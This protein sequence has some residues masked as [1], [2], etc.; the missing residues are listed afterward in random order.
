[1]QARNLPRPGNVCELENVIG[2]ACMMVDGNLIDISDLPE[3][4]RKPLNEEVGGDDTF[5]SLEELQRR[6]ILKVLEGGRRQQ[7]ACRRG[8]RDRTCHDLPIA[9]QDENRRDQ[10]SLRR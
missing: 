8:V 5:L 2:N 9:I 1:M 4:L 6:H 3:K 7:S 10:E